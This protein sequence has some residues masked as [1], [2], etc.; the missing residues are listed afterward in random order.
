MYVVGIDREQAER[1]GNT[2]ASPRVRFGCNGEHKAD[3]F[4]AR[5]SSADRANTVRLPAAA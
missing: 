4:M 3:L 2:V 1:A 5:R